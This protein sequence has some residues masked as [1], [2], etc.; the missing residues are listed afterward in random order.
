M[1]AGDELLKKT[2]K[3]TRSVAV[4]TTGV[5]V[6]GILSFSLAVP[7]AQQV[8]QLL[9]Q[10]QELDQTLW[11]AEEQAQHYEQR[12]VRLWDELLRSNNKYEI[13][14]RFPLATLVLGEVERRDSLAL[15]IT[16]ARFG[17]AHRELSSAAWKAR[18]DDFAEQGYVIDQTEWHHSRFVPAEGTR[19][20]QSEVSAI[21]HAAREEPPHRVILE[22]TLDITWSPQVDAED[23]PIPDRIVVSHLDVLEREAQ[24]AFQ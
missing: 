22:A 10:R 20:A 9:H 7:A 17:P 4:V 5:L 6:I 16:R 18:L 11:Q 23:L 12:I 14:K 1:V 3:S 21:I 8:Q 13:L 15:G 2:M 24:A 19:S